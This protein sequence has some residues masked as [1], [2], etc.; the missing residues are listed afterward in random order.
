MPGGGGLFVFMTI[1][2]SW[3][4]VVCTG[5]LCQIKLSALIGWLQS[6]VTE[7]ERSWQG[8]PY[9]LSPHCPQA[10]LESLGEL[11]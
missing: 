11:G 10:S 5:T 3:W 9:G 2:T 6:P 8:P 4:T 1:N 7:Q